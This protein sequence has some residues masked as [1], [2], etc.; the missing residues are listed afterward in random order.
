MNCSGSNHLF[1]SS[2]RSFVKGLSVLSSG[3]RGS[4]G[5]RATSGYSS[6]IWR[7]PSHWPVVGGLGDM[8]LPKFVR[9]R[10]MCWAICCVTA[11]RR[12]AMHRSHRRDRAPFSSCFGSN[13]RMSLLLPHPPQRNCFRRRR[14]CCAASRVSSGEGSGES[15]SLAAP[16]AAPRATHCLHRPR[17]P[18]CH[19][20]AENLRR[21]QGCPHEAHGR[22]ILLYIYVGSYNLN[23]WCTRVPGLYIRETVRCA[24]LERVF[25]RWRCQQQQQQT[26]RPSRA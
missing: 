26:L 7:M 23:L 5:R 20:L 18:F 10:D 9:S 14:R 25:P 19:W 16:A 6:I 21:E 24:G 13:S 12:P 4:T 8:Y 11:S 22:G 17:D 3:L 1:L 2:S 15:G